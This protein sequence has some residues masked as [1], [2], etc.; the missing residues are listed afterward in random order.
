MS[1]AG[2][3]LNDEEE[4]AESNA[5]AIRLKEQLVKM[6]LELKEK[7]EKLLELLD[8]LEEVKIQVFARDKSL[9]FQQ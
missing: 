8:E 4:K 5:E 7:N 6:N 9:E 3:P 2:G 1:N